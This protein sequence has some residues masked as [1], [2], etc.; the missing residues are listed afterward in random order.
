MK[1]TLMALLAFVIGIGIVLILNL[2]SAVK[3]A[4]ETGASAALGTDVSIKGMDVSL[5]DKSASMRGFSIKNPEGYKAEYLMKTEGVSI[6]VGEITEKAVIIKEVVVDGMTM[7]YEL[8]PQG[9]NFDAIRKNM[10]SSPGTPSKASSASGEGKEIVIEKLKI[11]NAKIIPALG[12][13]EAPIS[14]PDI[15]ISDIGS[16]SDPASPAEATSR[17][18]GKIMSAST[19]AVMKSGFTLPTS[20]AVTKAKEGLKNLLSLP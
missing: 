17:I 10:K 5:S 3:T 12:G 1:K 19:S 9:S 4:I 20:E 13:K 14:L 16:K 8:G 2:S 6:L 15:T 11:I 18:L 7:T